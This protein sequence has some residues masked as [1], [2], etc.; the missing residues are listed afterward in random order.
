LVSLMAIVPGVRGRAGC[1][2]RRRTG[3][4][5]GPVSRRVCCSKKTALVGHLHPSH[6]FSLRGVELP[7][8]PLARFF[9]V[10]MSSQISENTSLLALLLEPAE[11]TLEG[12]AFFDPNAGHPVYRL[13]T[14][15][16]GSNRTA[17]IG[18]SIRLTLRKI[19]RSDPLVKS[20]ANSPPRGGCGRRRGTRGRRFRWSIDWVPMR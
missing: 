19:P 1:R 15:V 2:P 13:L 18:G 14:W 7:L 6:H 17:P 16:R 8:S 12:L 9:E 20:A 4:R 5:R 10:L 3:N 11:G